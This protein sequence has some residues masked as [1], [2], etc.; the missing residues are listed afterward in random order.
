[1][2]TRIMRHEWRSL[3]AD[4]T[5]WIIAP[6]FALLIGYGVYNG[7][8]W[9]RFQQATLDAAQEEERARF[10]KARAEVAAIEQGGQPSSAFANP[11]L[12]SVAAGR[13]GP[14]YALLPPAPLAALSVGQSDLYPYYFKVSSQSKQTFTTND[15]IE[16]PTNLLAG[17]FDLAFV[18]I[19]LY[20]LLILALSYNLLSIEREQG[21]LQM[22]MSQPVSLRTFVTGKIGL[23]A[24]VVLLLA[25]G[26]SLAGFLL[27]G[28]RLGA[29][30]AWVRLLLWI[31]IVAGYGAFWFALAIAVNALGKSSATSAL[32]LAGL[33]LV[34]VL[35][36]PSLLNVAVTTLYPVPSRVEMVQATRRASAEAAA[37]GSQ[38]MSKYLEDH[39]KLTAGKQADPNDFV[40]RSLAIQ[41]E[42]ERLI[43]PVLDHFDQQTLGQQ[44]LVDRFRFLS[45]AVVTQ[46]ALNDIAGTSV[47][48]Y[49]HF[50]A[51]VDAF[52]QSWRAHFTPRI[53]QRTQLTAG[54]YDG[55][56]AF[57]FREE[58]SAAVSR[59]VLI[60]L[61][62]LLAP[63]L[64]VGW[65][66]LRALRRFSLAG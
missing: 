40:T 26:F 15:E 54:D 52:H 29:D 22:L 8:S 56:P 61:L 19:Y 14:R 50:L 12:P 66:G 51:L 7:S 38:L 16:N 64:L 35:L 21:T 55:F 32:A 33:W 44:T 42:T 6:L 53:V 17:R 43:Q 58:T 62:G 59:R 36:I 49:R 48:R 47:T 27:G 39:P 3:T 5:L 20:P 28:V 31:G 18:I 45:P 46:A 60:G 24:W 1:M 63:A 11:R 34:F 2:L 57:Q 13:T 10:A 9:V 65:Y 25:I 23:R 30:G 41:S 4:R 37:K